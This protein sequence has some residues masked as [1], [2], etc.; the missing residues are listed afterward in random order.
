MRGWFLP[1][2]VEAFWSLLGPFWCLSGRLLDTSALLFFEVN[3][4]VDA[5]KCVLRLGI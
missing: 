2:G 4:L 1:K 5:V 3:R